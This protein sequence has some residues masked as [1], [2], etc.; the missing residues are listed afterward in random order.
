MS[1]RIRLAVVVVLALL[2]FAGGIS[3]ATRHKWTASETRGARGEYEARS[4]KEGKAPELPELDLQALLVDPTQAYD[5]DAMA[6]KYAF[7]DAVILVSYQTA[8]NMENCGCSPIQLGGVAA[9]GALITGVRK[10]RPT[11]VIDLG[12]ITDGSDSFNLLKARYVLKAMD[13]AAYDAIGLGVA[14]LSLEPADLREFLRATATAYY[15]GN[16]YAS[17]WQPPDNWEKRYENRELLPILAAA[18]LPSLAG[19][20]TNTAQ[21]IA[22]PGFVWEVKSHRVGVLFLNFTGLSKPDLNLPGY[23]LAHPG[24]WLRVWS[25][26]ERWKLADTWVLAAEGYSAQ[27]AAVTTDYPQ[28]SLILTGDSHPAGRSEEEMLKPVETENGATWLNTFNY[29]GYLGLANVGW[30][31]RSTGKASF[32]AYNLPVISTFVPD[33]RIRELVKGE[34]H[35]ALAA[36]FPQQSFKYRAATIIP[37]E[38]CRQCHRQAYETF[39]KSAHPQSLATLQAKGQEQNAECLSCHVVDRK[40]VV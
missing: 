4:D 25:E 36:V 23:R 38:D 28:L 18:D 9:R 3:L 19:D 22:P 27:V 1:P 20:G 24:E 33:E 31:A 15:C 32:D 40:S 17:G 7:G 26:Q 16:A 6:L 30:G 11:L 14:E 10:R 5:A 35:D 13:L 34:F 37:P 39:K 2:V 21:G 12:A 29:G 8:G